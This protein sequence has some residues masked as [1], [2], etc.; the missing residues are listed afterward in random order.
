VADLAARLAARGGA[1]AA[2]VLFYGSA[3]RTD[4]LDGVLDFYVLLDSV[5]AWDGSRLA[6]CANRLLPPNVG[7]FEGDAGGR[8]L[9]AKYAVLTLAQFSRRMMVNSLDTTVWARFSQPCIC[10]WARS[11]QDRET[12]RAAV[13]AAVIAAA[14]WAAELGPASARPVDYWRA[15][16]EKTYAAELRIER[17]RRS[18][19][20]VERDAERYEK[21]LMPAWHEAGIG[22]DVIADGEV[23]PRLTE[24]TRRSA[25]RRWARRRRLGKPLNVA[26]LL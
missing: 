6:A 11:A 22:Y 14:W 17:S 12:V 5:R 13:V 16:F 10:V 3:L 26:R 18:T 2:A 4:D 20:I 9:R 24:A 7:Y 21:L 25:E 1:G 23:A 15:L 19:D 8:R